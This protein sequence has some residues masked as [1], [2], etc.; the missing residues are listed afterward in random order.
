MHKGTPS[1]WN[2]LINVATSDIRLSLTPLKGVENRKIIST[3]KVCVTYNTEAS[4]FIFPICFNVSFNKGDKF[5]AD[6]V[7]EG[8]EFLP[9]CN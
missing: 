6:F 7:K 2:Y 3:E 4:L 1:H 9:I 8:L 5:L